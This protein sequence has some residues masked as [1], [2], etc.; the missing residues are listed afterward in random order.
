MLL[1]VNLFTLFLTIYRLKFYSLIYFISY[2]EY[3]SRS[4]Q[5]GMTTQWDLICRSEPPQP[6]GVAL[7]ERF[8]MIL[9]SIKFYCNSGAAAVTLGTQ[10]VSEIFISVAICCFFSSERSSSSRQTAAG[11]PLKG[12]LVKAST[13]QNGTSILDVGIRPRRRG[14]NTVCMLSFLFLTRFYNKTGSV[15]NQFL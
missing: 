7:G 4:S 2:L 9:H 3:N 1:S 11:L 10:Q 8:S 6:K 14:N 13:V 15:Q 5:G 12:C